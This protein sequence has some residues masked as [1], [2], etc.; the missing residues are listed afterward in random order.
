MGDPRPIAWA[1]GEAEGLW[2]P[3]SQI[4]TLISLNIVE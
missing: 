4:Y 2:L 3:R 1:C